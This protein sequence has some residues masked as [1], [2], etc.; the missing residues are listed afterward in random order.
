MYACRFVWIV[1]KII[2]FLLI[3]FTNR[4]QTT[5]S[6]QALCCTCTCTSMPTRSTCIY[7]ARGNGSL[8][9]VYIYTMH[10]ES[11]AVAAQ[12]VKGVINDLIHL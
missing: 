7:I 4:K 6:S 2:L 12:N 5:V 8:V 9:V 10:V 3:K 1:Y 11:E